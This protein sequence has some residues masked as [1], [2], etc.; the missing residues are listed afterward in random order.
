MLDRPVMTGVPL[1]VGLVSVLLVSV[2]AE[3]SRSTVPDVL[4]RV[5]VRL[6]VGSI[7]LRVVV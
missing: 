3:S 5:M 1:M 2:V 7:T 4:G 6:A